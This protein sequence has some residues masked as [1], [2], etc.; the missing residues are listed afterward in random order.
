MSENLGHSVHL[1]PSGLNSRTMDWA[2]RQA[3]VRRKQSRASDYEGTEEE[4]EE[5]ITTHLT[6]AHK[7]KKE[8]LSSV[9]SAH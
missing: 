4:R 3:S 5:K 8:I 1:P 9:H 6:N 7:T 2:A